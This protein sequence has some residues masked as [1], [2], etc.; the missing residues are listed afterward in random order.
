LFNLNK[1]A[2]I[3]FDGHLSYPEII[4]NVVRIFI[5]VGI[6]L[7]L[8]FETYLWL[9]LPIGVMLLT[10]IMYIVKSDINRKKSGSANNNSNDRNNNNNN[11]N[12]N[13]SPTKLPSGVQDRFEQ[14]L[15]VNKCVK[16]SLENPFMNALVF[17][18]RNRKA[19]CNID[20]P[21]KARDIERY[22]NDGLYMSAS[23][24]FGKNNSQRE[25]YVMPVT[26]YPNDQD[27]FAKWLYGTPPTCKE[28]NGAQ[29]VANIMDTFSR[30]MEAPGY[31]SSK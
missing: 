11:N 1:L 4:N 26:T 15:D 19:A 8:V 29:C 12:N 31:G 17:D 3:S 22:F 16:P 18:P 30:R 10:F 23:D 14:F 27:A 5:L 25:F 21:E 6:V 24:I 20:S 9:W 28:G 7:C 13:N 2:Q